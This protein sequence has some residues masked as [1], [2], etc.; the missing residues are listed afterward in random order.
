MPLILILMPLMVSLSNHASVATID[1]DDAKNQ[2][3]SPTLKLDDPKN[4]AIV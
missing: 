3:K 2:S 1:S 4:E